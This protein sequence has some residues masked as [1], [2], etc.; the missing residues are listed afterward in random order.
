MVQRQKWLE[1][2]RDCLCS[3]HETIMYAV[4]THET[5]HVCSVNET[6]EHVTHNVSNERRPTRTIVLSCQRLHRE[7]RASFHG[8]S[9]IPFDSGVEVEI[10][11]PAWLHVGSSTGY[12]CHGISVWPLLRYKWCHA[13]DL[14]NMEWTE[15]VHGSSS[16]STTVN[17]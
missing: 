9:E 7:V 6:E 2:C 5:T 10:L 1:N 4:P 3:P 15:H 17:T 8:P 11:W 13:H 12:R 14:N 16:S